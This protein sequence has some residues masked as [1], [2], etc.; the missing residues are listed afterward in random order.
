MRS[1]GVKRSRGVKRCAPTKSR[2]DEPNGNIY[3]VYIIL[4]ESREKQCGP[5]FCK[6]IQY[7][8]NTRW[9]FKKMFWT[10]SLLSC[11]KSLT[12]NLLCKKINLEY[13]KHLKLFILSPFLKGCTFYSVVSL[14][15]MS[16][17]DNGYFGLKFK[18]NLDKEKINK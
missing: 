2:V 7:D 9:D 11:A 5:G 10:C 4:S 14:K 6:S 1:P 12:N 13:L 18:R 17:W 16:K 15:M 3:A 8:M